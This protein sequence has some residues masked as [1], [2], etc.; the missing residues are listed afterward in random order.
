MGKDK[1]MCTEPS[2]TEIQMNMTSFR[3]VDLRFCLQK[4]KEKGHNNYSECCLCFPN[5]F[6]YSKWNFETWNEE[7]LVC[8][9]SLIAK[10]GIR[11]S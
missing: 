10:D 3:S 4:G 9:A 8:E 2:K 6:L 7:F 11:F 1:K 5:P